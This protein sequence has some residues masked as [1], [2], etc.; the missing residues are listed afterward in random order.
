MS[1]MAVHLPQPLSARRAPR[2]VVAPKY[3]Y[4]S[5]TNTSI[6]DIVQSVIN[7]LDPQYVDPNFFA[8]LYPELQR[9]H[10]MLLHDGNVSAACAA[11]KGLDHIAQYYQRQWRKQEQQRLRIQ[12]REE[13]EAMM[14]QK[15]EEKRLREVPQEVLDKNVDHA[16]AGHFELIPTF[17]YKKLIR[18]LRRL[19]A[20]AIEDSDYASAGQYD[21]AARRVSVLTQEQ[22]YGEITSAMSAGWE[23]RVATARK[24]LHKTQEMWNG[25]ITEAKIE[26][27]KTA[28]V[29]QD[30]MQE[31]IEEYDKQL[32][33][34]IPL[35]YRKH[36]ARYLQLKEQE[37]FLVKSKRFLEA[38]A[39]HE[40]ANEL[41][42]Q[43]NEMFRQNYQKHIACQKALFERKMK[44][45]IYAK[46]TRTA[47]GLFLLERDGKRE[48]HNAKRALKWM[49]THYDE[50][51]NLASIA[52]QPPRLSSTG[53]MRRSHGFLERSPRTQ[54]MA[55]TCPIQRPFSKT[56][57]EVF[58]QQRAINN[59]IYSKMTLQ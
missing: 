22:R 37:K 10:E 40:E 16:L 51:E 33:L 59:I 44:D 6:T 54:Q 43:E 20:E 38:K 49:E 31:A 28:E 19:Q 24:G 21:R 57:Q 48:I 47:D 26:R 4:D 32:E 27:D 41:L 35:A 3:V 34:E 50:A 55:R 29:M 58:R 18:E 53:K 15:E 11:K 1:G 8:F 23:K 52:P 17:V 12:Q 42:R 46:E 13:Y 5:R 45:K 39:F 36:S 2:T 14:R 7:G 9:K 25:K 30:D 56:P